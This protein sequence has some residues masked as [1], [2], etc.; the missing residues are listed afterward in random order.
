MSDTCD[1]RKT[2]CDC[3]PFPHRKHSHPE[4]MCFQQM[5]LAFNAGQ[6]G[7]EWQNMI[8]AA[9]DELVK[10]VMIPAGFIGTWHERTAPLTGLVANKDI[11]VSIENGQLVLKQDE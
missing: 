3:Y 11:D 4:R 1:P 10:A 7:S 6:W 5:Y 2:G 8:D 9:H